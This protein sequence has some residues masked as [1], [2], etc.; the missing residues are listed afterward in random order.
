MVCVQ[1]CTN[2]GIFSSLSGEIENLIENLM[3]YL[4]NLFSLYAYRRAR[5]SSLLGPIE[6]AAGPRSWLPVVVSL[7]ILYSLL[8]V[9]P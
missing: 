4:F 9:A 2:R 1:V 6:N 3:R 8:V 5:C 7:A